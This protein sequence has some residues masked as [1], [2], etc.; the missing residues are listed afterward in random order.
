MQS[1]FSQSNQSTSQ[2][3]QVGK[4]SQVGLS[5]Q[6]IKQISV[7]P[8]F[9]SLDNKINRAEHSRTTAKT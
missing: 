5:H 6:R 4:L 7:D 8:C 1:E 2:T 9:H 3:K